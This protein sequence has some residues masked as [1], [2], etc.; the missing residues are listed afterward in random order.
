MKKSI[1]SG[2]E[3]VILAG[4]ARG[5]RAKVLQVL[6]QKQR[7]LVEGVNKRK[8]NERKSEA[9]PEGAVVERETPIHISN[10]MLA[11]RFDERQ[12]SKKNAQA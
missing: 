9:N 11:S 12:A 5:E 7:V 8:H 2:D 1:K 6:P 10:V 3:V 4:N